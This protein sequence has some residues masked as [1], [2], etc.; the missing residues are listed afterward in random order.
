LSNL[1]S[2]CTENTHEI[3]IAFARLRPAL[4]SITTMALLEVPPQIVLNVANADIKYVFY[5]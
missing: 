2:W 1:K 3:A 4:E 5:Y